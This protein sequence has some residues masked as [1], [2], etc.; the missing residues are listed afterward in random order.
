LD[1]TTVDA[2]LRAHPGWERHGSGT[3][4]GISRSYTF[5]DFATALSFVV[6]V[7]LLAEKRDHH[8]DV[9]L[10][11]GKT[12]LRW[13]THDAGGIS[14]LDLDAAEASDARAG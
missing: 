12:K 9:E 14:Q 10:G 7:G 5:P 3:N 4:A 1:D 2:W 11:W 6:R 8:P 13:S